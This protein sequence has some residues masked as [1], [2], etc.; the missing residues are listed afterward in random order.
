MAYITNIIKKAATDAK[1][2]YRQ[3]HLEEIVNILDSISASNI[4]IDSTL[5][6][7]T[8]ILQRGIS[9]QKSATVQ[10]LISKSASQ[11]WTSEERETH[12]L[13]ALQNFEKD[14]LRSLR[15]YAVL[16]KEGFTDCFRERVENAFNFGLKGHQVF[17][18]NLDGLE[19]N[20][21]IAYNELNEKCLLL[22]SE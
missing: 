13:A 12:N 2:K 18:E 1:L 17:N 4:E 11:N 8:D 6:V 10:M 19:I 5:I 22:E 3:G 9:P 15:K 16:Q 14:F 7:F 21:S 20:C